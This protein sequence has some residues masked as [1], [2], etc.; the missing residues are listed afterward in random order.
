MKKPSKTLNILSLVIFITAALIGFLF[1]TLAFWA[2]FEASLFASSITGDE[3]LS[4]LRCPI[5]IGNQENGVLK[6]NINNPLE[7]D[8]APV[9]RGNVSEGL[10]TLI[11]QEEYKPSLAPGETQ[12]LE[13]LVSPEDAAWNRFILFRV[14]QLPV[15]PIPSLTNTCGVVVVPLP[16]NG[17]WFTPVLALGSLLGMG[18]GLMLWVSNNKPLNKR[19]RE[20]AI[21]MVAVALVMLTG[22]IAAYTA[23]MLVGLL[24]VVIS[25]LLAVAMLAYFS[26]D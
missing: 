16:V 5:L 3:N 19:T 15:Y 1:N 2:D 14:N 13:F 8:I 6:L 22:I 21:A 20:A 7:R 18:A 12:A 11:R 26:R 24:L 10:V 4:G 9:V 17:S 25:I 23:Q